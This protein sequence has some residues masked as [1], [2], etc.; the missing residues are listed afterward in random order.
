MTD[1]C[2]TYKVWRLAIGQT[3]L[4]YKVSWVS[5]GLVDKYLSIL[6]GKLDCIRKL[7][8]RPMIYIKIKRLLVSIKQVE[9]YGGKNMNCIL[10][11][12]S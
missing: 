3:S 5:L 6:P 11:L 9:N 12:I 10:V 2:M 7:K 4:L 8:S 1:T